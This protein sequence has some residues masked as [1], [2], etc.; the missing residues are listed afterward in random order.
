MLSLLLKIFRHGDRAPTYT[1]PN[2]PYNDTSHYWPEGL[3]QL[4]NVSILRFLLIL[5]KMPLAASVSFPYTTLNEP[6]NLRFLVK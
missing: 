1:Y 3:A 2:D 4:T 6:L 5:Y